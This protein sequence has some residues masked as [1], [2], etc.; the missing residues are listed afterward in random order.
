MIRV[1]QKGS[2]SNTEAFFNR[3]LNRN[4][5]NILDKYGQLGV[6]LLKSETPVRTGEVESSWGYEIEESRKGLITLSFTNSAEN[7]GRNIVLLLMYGHG[8]NN[9]GYVEGE[10]FVTPAVRPLL[11]ELANS[12]WKEVTA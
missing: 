3:V 1:K 4:Y 5:L 10:D 8:T 12:L 11:H 7:D 9:G 2:F 6:Q